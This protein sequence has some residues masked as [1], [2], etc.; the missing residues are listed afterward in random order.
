MVNVR[1]TSV[2]SSYINLFGKFK[3]NLNTT[4][5]FL[6]ARGGGG[7]GGRGGGEGGEVV[8]L[9]ESWTSSLK[10]KFNAVTPCIQARLCCHP[11]KR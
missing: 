6:G 1:K 5:C 11:T 7:G 8:I 10:Q 9:S 2:T 4:V 3:F